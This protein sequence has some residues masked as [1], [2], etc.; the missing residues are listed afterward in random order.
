M[1]V[2]DART[3]GGSGSTEAPGT[4]T[5]LGGAFPMKGT[6]RTEQYFL[7]GSRARAEE[8]E[9]DVTAGRANLG[10]T[11]DARG[12]GDSFRATEDMNSD[13]LYEVDVLV[14]LS[15]ID[16]IRI[17]KP[18][19]RGLRGWINSSTTKSLQTNK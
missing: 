10:G 13:F 5:V 1:T 14:V 9:L 2:L 17:F 4:D 7:A 19:T 12:G 3:V 11:G 16:I 15:N 6:L 18:S 8:S